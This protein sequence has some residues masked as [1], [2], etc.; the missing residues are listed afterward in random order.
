MMKSKNNRRGGKGA[1]AGSRTDRREQPFSNRQSS[2]TPAAA[3]LRD[4][5]VTKNEDYIAEIVG[6]GHD[7]EGVGR[8]NGFTLFCS[9]RAAGREGAGQGS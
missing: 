5:P 7:G 6:L 3:V 1:Q 4:L 2:P 9:R 8:V